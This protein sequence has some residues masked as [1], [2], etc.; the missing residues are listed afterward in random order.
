M[1][2]FIS[3]LPVEGGNTIALPVHQV[4]LI[5]KTTPCISLPPSKYHE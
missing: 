2:I 4:P 1:I 3:N 5:P